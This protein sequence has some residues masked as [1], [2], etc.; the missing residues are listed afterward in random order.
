MNKISKRRKIIGAVSLT[1]LL[2]LVGWFFTKDGGK[3][4]YHSTKE[5]RYPIERYL[6]YVQ[7]NFDYLLKEKNIPIEL[8]RFNDKK[9]LNLLDENQVSIFSD[10]KVSLEDMHFID[11]LKAWDAISLND[12]MEDGREAIWYYNAELAVY[13]GSP[14][15]RDAA[16]HPEK[17]ISDVIAFLPGIKK[18]Y[19]LGYQKLRSDQKDFIKKQMINDGVSD[20][21]V[22]KEPRPYIDA[23]VAGKEGCFLSYDGSEHI[24]YYQIYDRK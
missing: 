15:R 21:V 2:I 16:D 7:V 18:E 17:D 14:D 12:F 4:S 10:P 19:C 3:K 20:Y 23:L 11:A 24:L 9:S 8:I 6:I 13:H 1:A 5:L 22:P